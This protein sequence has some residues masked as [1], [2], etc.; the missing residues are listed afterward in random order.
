MNEDN[1]RKLDQL[2]QQAMS[3]IAGT[4][5]ETVSARHDEIGAPGDQLTA[6]SIADLS[7]TLASDRLHAVA[8]DA[9]G[10]IGHAISGVGGSDQAHRDSEALSIIQDGATEHQTE[11]FRCRTCARILGP[12]ALQDDECRT[13]SR[14]DNLESYRAEVDRSL[15]HANAFV[16]EAEAQR[17][18]APG[19]VDRLFGADSD[20]RFQGKPS[21]GANRTKELRDKSHRVRKMHKKW[22]E[23]GSLPG[24]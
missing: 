9:I 8:P 18:L 10:A 11:R 22:K 23:A 2:A 20:V 6:S 5:S 3:N 15:P 17:R 24:S 4:A 7:S 19:S 12:D 21:P 14:N 13:C 16:R 1:A